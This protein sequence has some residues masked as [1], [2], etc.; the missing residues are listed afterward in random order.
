MPIPLLGMGLM[1]G[2]SWLAQKA[3][4][5]FMPPRAVTRPIPQVMP[6][7]QR[8]EPFPSRGLGASVATGETFA[9]NTAEDL[10]AFIIIAQ[11]FGPDV[12]MSLIGGN[13]RTAAPPNLAAPGRRMD[14]WGG[15][16]RHM[17]PQDQRFQ[18]QNLLMPRNPTLDLYPPPPPIQQ[19]PQFRAALPI[20][21]PP[22]PMRHMGWTK[23]VRQQGGMTVVAVPK[24]PLSPPTYKPAQPKPINYAQKIAQAAVVA[25]APALPIFKTIG[26]LFS[27]G[28]RYYGGGNND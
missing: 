5:Y 1:I 9:I 12:A 25:I 24:A 26:K 16:A 13:T 23:T 28:K 10:E 6:P 22:P 3:T 21:P 15:M 11:I 20:T 7:V 14:P 4:E 19:I 2:G 27:K 18:A 8:A 17:G